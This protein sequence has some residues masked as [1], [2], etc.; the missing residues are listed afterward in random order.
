LV[1]YCSGG[2]FRSGLRHGQRGGS[3]PAQCGREHRAEDHR[4]V[5]PALPAD[6]ELGAEHQDVS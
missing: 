3:R 1:F 4:L 2:F 6:E 5:L